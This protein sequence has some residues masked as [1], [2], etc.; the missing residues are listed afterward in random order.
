MNFDTLADFN[1]VATHGGFG[2]ASRASGRA[3]ATLSRRVMELE[4]SLGLRLLERGGRAFRLT[5]DGQVLYA[6]TEGLLAEIEEVSKCLAS[7]QAKGARGTLRISC[8]LLFAHTAMGRLAAEFIRR[9][10]QVVIEV[11]T[12]DRM[13]DLVEENYDVVIR[14]NPPPDSELVGRCFLRD[15]KLVVAAPTI[16]RPRVGAAVP[17]VLL[18]S[19]SDTTPW[20]VQAANSQYEFLP[21]AVLRLS[22]IC[23]VR[24][25]A[26]AGAGA[27][28]LP[29]SLVRED[30]A[31]GR[32]VNWGEV[33]QGRVEV[34]ALHTSRRLVS[35]KVSAFVQFLCDAFP[36]NA[37][38]L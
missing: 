26:L 6:R 15:Q 21:S 10:P 5:Q 27:A 31:E 3:K 11:T 22:S 19:T 24:D 2:K 36:E 20:R 8:P 29:S 38:G 25:A 1:L 13:V 7:G 17:A 23:M 37:A 4:E 32:L 34:W 30:L 12:E 16:G 9:Y 35:S 28:M 14:T 33:M 18:A